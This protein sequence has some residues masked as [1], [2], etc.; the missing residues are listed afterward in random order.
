GAGAGP[1]ILL[2]DD[3]DA[4]RRRVGETLR[5]AGYRVL[6][7]D[8][9]DAGLAMIQAG[10]PTVDALVTDVVMPRMDGPTLARRARAL[11]PELPVVFITGYAADALDD[12]PEAGT[13]VL[14]KP[15]AAEDLLAAL[16]SLLAGGP[17]TP[18]AR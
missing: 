15:F 13:Q 9:G 6:E 10:T 17:A 4:V 16:R 11:R 8:D 18:D 7:A 12:V 2:C 5:A 3:N 14:H 1:T